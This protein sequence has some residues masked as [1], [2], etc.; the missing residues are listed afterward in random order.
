M[1]RHIT[2]CDEG[3]AGAFD[4]ADFPPFLA[5]GASSAAAGVVGA[6]DGVAGTFPGDSSPACWF[7]F[8]PIVCYF[9]GAGYGIGFS[10]DSSW[11]PFRVG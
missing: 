7:F 10:A 3:E 1:F 6:D 11:R 9:Y 2:S 5:G 8:P 4:L